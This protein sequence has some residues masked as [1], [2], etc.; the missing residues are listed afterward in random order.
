MNYTSE[1]SG[2]PRERAA[3]ADSQTARTLFEYD[4]KPAS[5][6]LALVIVAVSLGMFITLIPFASTPLA[7]APWFIPLHQPVLAINDLITTTL[8]LGYFYLTRRKAILVLACGYLYSAVMATVHLLS[9]PGVFT[10]TGLL[11]A[12]PQ[13]TG[14]L[15]VFWHLGFPVAVIAYSFLKQTGRPAEK[16]GRATAKAMLVT[17]A[18]AAVLGTL[19]TAGGDWL[20]QMLTDNRYSSAFNIGR[21]GQWFVTGLALVILF[22]RRSASALDMWLG[23]VLSAWF[24]EIGLVSVFNAGRW[25]VGFYAGRAYGLVASIF[26]LI[27]LLVEHGRMHRDLAE[28]Q[29]TART[30]ARLQEMQQVLRLALKAGRMG[31]FSWDLVNDRAWWSPEVEQDI[32]GLRAG[33]L[34]AQPDALTDYVFAE[35]RDRLRADPR[36]HRQPARMR[37]RVPPARRAR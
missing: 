20:P 8:L 27:M 10:P 26:V 5:R 14:Y 4:A 29:A 7:A 16:P 17:L 32:L 1:W 12:G 9:F 21:Y 13:T 30:A 22:T 19:A 11:G 15:H 34:A 28:A 6:R 31:V 24:F 3:S 36:M 23:V 35:D 25:D 2:I 18:C 33:E 37:C